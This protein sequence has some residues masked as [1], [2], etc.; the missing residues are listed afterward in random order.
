LRDVSFEQCFE[1]NTTA[2]GVGKTLPIVFKEY[3]RRHMVY[4][5]STI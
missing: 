4:W 3:K 5:Y 2:D 1:C